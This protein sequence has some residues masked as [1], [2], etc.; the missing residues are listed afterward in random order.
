MSNFK[1][2]VFKQS[3]TWRLLFYA[4]KDL[5]DRYV[6]SRNINV[7][8]SLKVDPISSF[9]FIKTA[10]QISK[11]SFKYEKQKNGNCTNQYTGQKSLIKRIKQ[12]IIENA[13]VIL[14]ESYF[15][16]DS[17]FVNLNLRKVFA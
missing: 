5:K 10:D 8:N 16:L 17:S 14:F 11:G 1:P 13:L 3:F 4:W 6:N 2:F 15:H 12:R 9:W 7:Y